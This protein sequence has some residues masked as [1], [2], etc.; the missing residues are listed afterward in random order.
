[1]YIIKIEKYLYNLCIEMLPPPLD[2][3]QLL[4]GHSEGLKIRKVIPSLRNENKKQQYEIMIQSFIL[5]LS[6]RS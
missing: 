6:L 2:D 4:K 3:L 5:L 1:M